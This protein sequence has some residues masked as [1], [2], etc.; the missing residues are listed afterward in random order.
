M[1][2]FIL[3][4]AFGTSLILAHEIK[5][6]SVIKTYHFLPLIK[7]EEWDHFDNWYDYDNFYLKNNKHK[8]HTDEKKFAIVLN[9]LLRQSQ[10]LSQNLI[11]VIEKSKLKTTDIQYINSKIIKGEVLNPQILETL[12]E[13]KKNITNNLRQQ[14]PSA[15]P[16]LQDISCIGLGFTRMTY[17]EK[18]YWNIIVDDY[19]KYCHCYIYPDQ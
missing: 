12:K 5:K 10:P 19:R 14:H 9:E 7:E 13:V 15:N 6:S 3:G 4:T 1:L 11:S 8:S 16:I 17:I 2:S 18:F